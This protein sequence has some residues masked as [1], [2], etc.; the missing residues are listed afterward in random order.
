MQLFFCFWQKHKN[1]DFDPP[2]SMTLFENETNSFKLLDDSFIDEDMNINEELWMSSYIVCYAKCW[3]RKLNIVI[4][5]L[6]LIVSHFVYLWLSFSLALAKLAFAFVTYDQGYRENLFSN[7]L[8]HQMGFTLLGLCRRHPLVS[9][10]LLWVER[11]LPHMSAFL[12]TLNF[13]YK[14]SAKV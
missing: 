6:C 2:P 1:T 9:C 11:F 14:L 5:I 4:Y 3:L 13:S 12:P 7:F 10:P 8:S